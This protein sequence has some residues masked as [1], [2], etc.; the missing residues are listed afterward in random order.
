[1]KPVSSLLLAPA[2][3]LDFDVILG[4][5]AIA[6]YCQ[7]WFLALPRL[8]VDNVTRDEIQWD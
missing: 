2:I 8:I 3:E 7:R 6:W 1:M 5:L 4:T